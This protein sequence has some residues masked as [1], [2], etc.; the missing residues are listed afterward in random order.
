MS[1]K[2]YVVWVGNNPGIYENA[3]V[4]ATY[5]YRYGLLNANYSVGAAVGIFNTIISLF[6]LVSVNTIFRRFTEESL[7]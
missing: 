4:I 3:D 5:M 1:K 6:I 7:W 2:W